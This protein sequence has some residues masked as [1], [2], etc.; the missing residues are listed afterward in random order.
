MKYFQFI[1]NIMQF[2]AEGAFKAEAVMAKN[3]FYELAGMFD[4]QSQNFDLKMSQ[5]NDWYIFHR[6]LSQYKKTP[7]QYFVENWPVD[8]SEEDKLLYMNLA[9][10]RYSLFEFLKIKNGDLYVRDLFSKY[11]LI[12]KNSPVTYGFETDVYFQARLI[13]HEDTFVFSTAYCFHPPDATKFLQAEVKKVMKLPELEQ[14]EA[15]EAAL[16]RF[17][18]MRNKFEQYQHVGIQEIYSNESRLRV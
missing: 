11:K 4:E 13:P 7:I 9:N 5:F 10:N 6:K 1:D 12:I 8:L 3:E 17:F 15:R 2:F 14:K 18:R 16:N